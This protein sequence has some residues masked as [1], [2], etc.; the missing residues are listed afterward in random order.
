MRSAY[1]RL[2]R[3]LLFSVDPETAHRVTIGSL[4][5]ASRVDPVLR[6]LK[7]FQPSAKPK[8]VFGLD[9]PNPIGLAAG[10]DKNG[11]AL[12]AWAAGGPTLDKVKER[13]HLECGVHLGLPGFSS[14]D[15]KQT[16]RP[17]VDFGA[18]EYG[19]SVA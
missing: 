2:V 4:R 6:A 13:G 10:L 16:P 19:W 3:P 1:E 11:V 17:R 14:P 5:A 9:F 12:P 18:Q 15:D 8:R 7:L